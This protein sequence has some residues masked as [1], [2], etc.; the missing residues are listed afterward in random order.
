MTKSTQ[1]C[2]AL[3]QLQTSV[4]ALLLVGASIAG[5]VQ[6]QSVRCQSVWRLVNKRCCC[7]YNRVVVIS[8]IECA[9]QLM[10]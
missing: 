3:R 10:N 7:S 8:I 1:L 9:I 6:C 2:L 4:V 5:A